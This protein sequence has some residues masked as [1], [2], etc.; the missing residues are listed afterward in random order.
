M[1]SW[2]LTRY[3]QSRPFN[4]VALAFAAV[5]CVL[6]IHCIHAAIS[7]ALNTIG[8]P[9]VAATSLATAVTHRDNDRGTTRTCTRSWSPRD[10]VFD[11]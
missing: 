7:K 1:D 4:W 2:R 8:P 3:A 5:S 10:D 6:S 11:C 9:A